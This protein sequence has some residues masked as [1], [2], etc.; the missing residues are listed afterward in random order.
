MSTIVSNA[1]NVRLKLLDNLSGYKVHH[2][3]VDPRGYKV[4]LASGEIIGDVEG[5]LADPS[6]EVIRYLEIEI[7]DNVIERHTIGRYQANDRHA[8]IPIGLIA[9][10][11]LSKTVSVEGL[12]F[13]H[14]V[15]Y[16]RF[17][18]DQGYTTRYEIDT[19]DYLSN[20]H[21]YG[22]TYDRNRYST[23]EYRN[24][25]TLDNGFYA[26]SFYATPPR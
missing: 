14:L 17:R 2:D 11:T 26:S 7:D 10:D 25:T 12:G 6:A 15:D 8:L 22:N 13:N 16:P 23:D 1:H 9:I 5:L 19:N 24:A 18:R 4:K 3:D 20:F 21:E